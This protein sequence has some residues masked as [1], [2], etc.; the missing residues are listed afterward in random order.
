MQEAR[1]LVLSWH[2]Q[3]RLPAGMQFS[4]RN[5]L[6]GAEGIYSEY[7]SGGDVRRINDQNRISLPSVERTRSQ[8]PVSWLRAGESPLSTICRTLRIRSNS[9][10]LQKE[11]HAACGL[12]A[13]LIHSFPH[14]V[15][16]YCHIFSKCMLQYTLA[17]CYRNLLDEPPEILYVLVQISGLLATLA[18]AKTVCRKSLPVGAA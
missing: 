1:F 2:K 8:S 16:E 5:R 13:G 4:R 12:S 14:R 9:R 10:V 15:T 6:A 3:Q 7:C 17:V 11:V 18:N